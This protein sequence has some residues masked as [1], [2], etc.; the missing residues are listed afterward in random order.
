MRRN[1]VLAAFAI[2]EQE[3]YHRDERSDRTDHREQASTATTVAVRAMP[4]TSHM[5]MMV[6]HGRSV[7][8]STAHWVSVVMT[9]KS[10]AAGASVMSAG[11]SKTAGSSGSG[12]KSFL[13]KNYLSHLV[14]LEPNI[15]G[16]LLPTLWPDLS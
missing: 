16:S 15:P 7:V 2:L 14:F 8:H 11:A 4:A 1:R 13:L 12:H 10:G 6:L 3:R 9:A 5:V